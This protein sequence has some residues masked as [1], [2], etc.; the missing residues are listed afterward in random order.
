MAHQRQIDPAIGGQTDVGEVDARLAALADRQHGRVG[1]RQLLALGLGKHAIDH[2]V[3]RR[4]LHPEYRGVYAV[5]YAR[6]TRRGRWMAAVLA[7]GEGTV[8]SHRAAA[9]LWGLCP[10]RAGEVE[11]SVPRVREPQQGIRFYRNAPAPDEITTVDGIPV[12]TVPRTLFDLAAVAEQRGL[13]RALNEA[14]VLALRDPLCLDDLLARYPRRPGSAIARAALAARRAGASA[15]RSELEERFLKLIDEGGLPRPETNAPL[16]VGGQ[17]FEVDCLW[18][19][20]RLVV[21]LDGRAAH[22]TP[23]AFERDRARDRSLQAAG[24]RPVRITWRQLHD[25]G[26]TLESDLRRMLAA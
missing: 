8:L 10:P 9:A 17:T 4:R 18:R 13:E 7:G 5:G 26:R 11:V 15:T 2:L 25:H 14:D 22:A 20:Q 3:R 24:W 23:L 19:A 21:E 16:S 12:T 1:R 6:P